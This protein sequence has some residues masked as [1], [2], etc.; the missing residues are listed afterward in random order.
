M[1]YESELIKPG[2]LKI[3][4][5]YRK[6]LL[7]FYAIDNN[8]TLVIPDFPSNIFL[9]D[10]MS[11]YRIKDII[12]NCCLITSQQKSIIQSHTN[13]LIIIEKVI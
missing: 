10:D 5:V 2:E 4:E 8:C 3:G 13:S 1:A 6:E 7:D 11:K 9:S 12:N